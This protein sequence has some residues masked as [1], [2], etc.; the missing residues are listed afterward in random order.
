MRDSG[1][2]SLR[3]ELALKGIERGVIDGVLAGRRG[4]VGDPD[5]PFT[6]TV[7]GDPDREAAER[8]LDRK[9][10]ALLRE[11]DPRKRRQKAYALLARNGFA[12]DVASEVAR[13]IDGSGDASERDT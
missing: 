7:A 6:T 9:R 2:G 11:T 3:R 5:D 8:L 10:A 1:I 12:P 4:E 13:R